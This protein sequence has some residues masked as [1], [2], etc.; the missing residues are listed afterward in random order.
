MIPGFT[1]TQALFLVISAA[2]LTGS[3][4]FHTKQKNG[5]AILLLT[6]SAFSL[7]CFAALL[8]PF[9]NIW[10]ERF[11]ALVARNMMENPFKPMLYA[12][13]VML[14]K[15]DNWDKYHVWLHKQP[16]F[17]WQIA[18]SFKLFG[19]SEFALRIPNI[20]MGTLL[21]YPAYR[22]GKLLVNERTGFLC[23]LLIMSSWIMVE[24]VSGRQEMEH[25]DIAFFFYVS[26][27]IW[28]WLEFIHSGKRKWI[29]L[30]GLF[31]GC[32]ILCKWVVGLLVFGGW[33]LYLILEKRFNWE[34]I[35][36]MLLA[37]VI[38]VTVA[39]PWQ[40]YIFS[41]FPAEAAKSY[42]FN[43]QH[44]T[45][46]VD[47]HD[48]PWYYH[49]EKLTYIYGKVFAFLLLPALILFY[50]KVRQ[51]SLAWSLY[52]MIA[53][54]FLF[55]TITATKA[56]MYTFCCGLLIFIVLAAM[57][58]ELFSM[59]TSLIGSGRISLL[60]LLS[61]VFLNLDLPKIKMDH[62]LE[63]PTNTHSKSLKE[64]RDYFR[65]LELPPNT[66]LCNVLGRHYIEAMFYTGLPAYTGIPTEE[67]IKDLQAKGRRIVMF[68]PLEGQ[69]PD[70]I[71]NDPHIT[72]YQEVLKGY[73]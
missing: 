63:E 57:L 60:L 68:K 64:N 50:R 7:Y 31:V 54:V 61:F 46:P 34:E 58:D 33:G 18:L 36:W 5:Y 51:K 70:Y 23:S 43:I 27:S 44:F 71:L 1:S 47:G 65:T 16:L 26:L 59:L 62:S 9:L 28:T 4:V 48:G 12:D 11:H 30:I 72:N 20:I 21:I 35:K 69:L 49:F 32:A 45:M 2:L 42:E 41:A 39:V 25:N 40:I 3:L 13:P 66:V 24:L 17:L 38:A 55:F 29:V 73:Y 8:D 53:V 10:D 37:A 6:L 14:M 56:P 15:Y 22:A 19:I 67:Q 52:A